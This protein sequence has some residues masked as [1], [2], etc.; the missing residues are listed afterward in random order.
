MKD[1]DRTEKEGRQVDFYTDKIARNLRIS[2]VTCLQ[3]QQQLLQQ[4][5]QQQQAQHILLLGMFNV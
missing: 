1:R 5:Q 3:Q 2:T 4:Q